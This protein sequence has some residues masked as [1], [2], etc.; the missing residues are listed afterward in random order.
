MSIR[1]SGVIRLTVS[2]I[3]KFLKILKTLQNFFWKKCQQKYPRILIRTQ[4]FRFSHVNHSFHQIL[5][6]PY[7]DE[8]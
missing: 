3:A 1:V 5:T 6:P 8:I 7:K 2:T 4:K